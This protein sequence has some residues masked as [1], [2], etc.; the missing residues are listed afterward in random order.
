MK[1]NDLP[2]FEW[3]CNENINVIGGERAQS[4]LSYDKMKMYV[5]GL[6]P[7]ITNE[8]S[9]VE[10]FLRF[11]FGEN[12]YEISQ[13]VYDGWDESLNRNSI[14]LDLK[15]LTSLKLQDSSNVKRFQPADILRFNR[16]KRISIYRSAWSGNWEKNYN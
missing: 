14:D 7:W 2:G 5:H 11:G 15:W 3:S 1:F 12:Y 8:S 6:S 16:P 9:P 13:P 4:Y 10:M